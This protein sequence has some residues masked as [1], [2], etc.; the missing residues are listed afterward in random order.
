M[1]R[2]AALRAGFGKH[3]RTVGKIEGC[4]T[5][6][7]RQFRPWRPPVQPASNHQVQHQPEVAIHTDGDS[8]A[9]PSQFAHGAAL[10]FRNW[11]LYGSKQKR[12]RQSNALDRLGN[13]AGFEGTDVGG[14]IRQ[15][16][17]GLQI[18]AHSTLLQPHILLLKKLDLV[19]GIPT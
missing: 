17:H 15:F 14:D 10:G 16:W 7:A 19:D 13:D 11:W 5:L 4:Q 18:A 9:D 6:P 2:C 8:L 12:A 3:E 1:Q